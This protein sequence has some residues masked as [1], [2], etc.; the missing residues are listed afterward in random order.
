MHLT[1]VGPVYP[2]RGGIAHFTTALAHA[3]K[4][5]H[6]V[7]VI[8]YQRQYPKWLYPGQTD[9]DP[10]LQPQT[11]EAEY[12]LDSLKPLSWRRT[13][14]SII[15]HGTDM[16]IMQWWTTFWAPANFTIGHILRKA[17]IPLVYIVHNVLPHET[18]I[19]DAAITYRTLTKATKLLALSVQ[20]QQ[21]LQAMFPQST[22]LYAPLPVSAPASQSHVTKVEARSHLGLPA[23]ERIVLFFGFVRPYKGLMLLLQS[24]AY[25]RQQGA[26]IHVLVAGEFWEDIAPYIRYVQEHGLQKHVTL[27]AE[28]IPN[29]RLSLYFAA[30]DAFAAPYT[31]ATQSSALKTAMRF[32]LPI[33]ATD[34]ALDRSEVPQS[35][36]LFFA[37]AN[38]IHGFATALSKAVSAPRGHID[39]RLTWQRLVQVLETM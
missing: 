34:T 38:D 11:V 4:E 39:H 7:R 23:S 24:L 25:L 8:S 19:W 27:H 10:S 12:L 21:R 32:G 5:R 31:S 26:P 1:L 9:H 2:Y 22:V 3:L 14:K 36:P 17:N 37:S 18:K 35:Y 13:A 20:E 6:T 28:Y 16:V 29:E 33:A 15:S 30:A